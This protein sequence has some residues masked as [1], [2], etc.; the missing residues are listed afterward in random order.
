[1]GNLCGIQNAATYPTAGKT[2]DN[3]EIAQN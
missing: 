2:A 1:M 3:Y